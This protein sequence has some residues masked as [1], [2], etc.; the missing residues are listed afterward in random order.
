MLVGLIGWM[1]AVKQ[2]LLTRFVPATVGARIPTYAMTEH[3]SERGVPAQQVSVMELIYVIPPTASACNPAAL[4][5]I[6]HLGSLVPAECA[7][8]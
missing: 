5:S 1:D 8:S 3:A 7:N 2:T 4:T 6:A